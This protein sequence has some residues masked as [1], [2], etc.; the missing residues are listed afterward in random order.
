MNFLNQLKQR[1]A[2]LYWFGWFNLAVG[3]TCFVGT[4][5][6]DLKLL[7]VSRWLK[8]MKFYLSVGIMIWTLGW[9]MHYLE[10][11][12]K[13]RR[14]SWMIV[15]TMFFE[16]GLILMQAIRNTTSHFNNKTPF[17][18][19]VFSIMGVLILVFTVVCIRICIAFFAQKQFNIPIAYLWGIRLGLLFFIIF[20]LEGFIM[21]SMLKHTVGAADGS[22]GLP[23]LNWSRQYGDLRIA[24]FL[25]IHSLQVLP[26]IG[27]YFLETKRQ[28]MITAAVY[29]VL[30]IFVFTQALK[31]VPLF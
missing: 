24:H 31:G 27:F 23:L 25:G 30:T 18:S 12:K 17:D 4:Y 9:L 1:N 22:P 11:R 5:S 16:N 20:S 3:I 26:I 2:L 14:F 21:V 8:P 28:L 7:G 13:V 10:N 15:V 19:I 29:F 6:D